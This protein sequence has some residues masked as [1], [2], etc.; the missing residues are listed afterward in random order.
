M[1]VE[2]EEGRRGAK[3]VGGREGGDRDV[4]GEKREQADK[5][6]E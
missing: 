3:E 6:V 5:E 4:K 2:E 1:E